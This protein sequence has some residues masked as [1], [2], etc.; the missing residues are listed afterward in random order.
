MITEAQKRAINKY[1]NKNMKVISFRL[2]K[3][4]EA[5]LIEVFDR[6]EN[7]AEWFRECL[8]REGHDRENDREADPV[9]R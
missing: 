6:I 9:S 8:R 5:D 4:T 2:H 7:K 1:R 3:E